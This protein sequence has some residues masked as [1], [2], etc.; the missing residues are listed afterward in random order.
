MNSRGLHIRLAL[1]LALQLTVGMLILLT[2]PGSRRI[3]VHAQGGTHRY[4][5]PGGTDGGNDCT[6]SDSPCRSV[7]HA[8]DQANEGDDIRV[9]AGLYTDLS[10]RPRRD[11]TAAGVV[12]QVLYIS[13]S[14]AVRGGYT[15]TNWTTP[16]PQRNPTTLDARGRGRV[17]YV[18]GE[19]NPTIEGLRITGGD[20]SGLGGLALGT[21]GG[22]H[23]GGGVYVISATA[24]LKDNHVFSNTVSGAGYGGGFCLCSSRA[25]L[26]GN[27]V[28]SN[29]AS[30]GGGL[31]LHAADSTLNENTISSST[32]GS[33]GGGLYLWTSHA[34]ISRNAIVSNTAR[35]GGGLRAS[36]GSP[37]LSDNTIAYNSADNLGGGLCLSGFDHGTLAGNAISSNRAGAAGGGLHIYW[38]RFATL[39]GNAFISNSTEGSGGGLSVDG[40][41]RTTLSANT[42]I[43][44]SAGHSGGGLRMGAS[45][46]TSMVNNVVSDNRA[47]VAGSGLS[48]DGSSARLLHTTVTHNTG[49]D[50]SGIHI[51]ELW[52]GPGFPS[53]EYSTVWMTNTILHNQTV[54]ISVTAHNTVTIGGVL[55]YSTP[56][57]VSE[58]ALAAVIAEGQYQGD[59]AFGADGYHLTAGSAAIDR[60]LRAAVTTDIDG[61]TRDQSTLPDLG[62]DEYVAWRI[63]YL[64]VVMN[65]R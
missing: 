54:G 4:V 23:A 16:D 62:A 29:T 11:V 33:E 60:G 5:A 19:I 65:G 40:T 15:T 52:P 26:S 6:R 7:Q 39:D 63:T 2:P 24:T 51:T 58:S 61:E 22:G 48:I 53:K 32:A 41:A 30:S 34:S 14:I 50:G 9:A 3:E 35:I 37:T 56:V 38:S 25:S 43:S 47:L 8:V 59:P 20:A 42:I 1:T 31:Y 46:D 44:N 45:G 57:T 27:T 28:T 21:P 64:P 12:T 13:K 49:G 55:W 10:A 18:T 36:E 17:I